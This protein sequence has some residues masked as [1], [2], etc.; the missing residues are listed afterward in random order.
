MSAPRIN[1]NVLDVPNPCSVPWDSMEGD[2]QVRFCRE[3]S[4]HVF[5]LSNMTRAEAERLV[6]Q[7]EGSLCVQFWRRADGTVVTRDCSVVRV[8][9]EAGNAVFLAITC[10]LMVVLFFFT[11]RR[12]DW[13]APA[14][15]TFS[16]VSGGAIRPAG[17]S[18]SESPAVPVDPK[19]DELP[20]PRAVR[21]VTEAAPPP[22]PVP[23]AEK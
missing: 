23:A 11:W 15:Q 4:K 6:L 18:R 9:K 14:N 22:R 1:L 3:C 10:V 7:A 20:P 21:A 13:F 2:D 19:A 5:H 17:W 16:T 12:L 8:A